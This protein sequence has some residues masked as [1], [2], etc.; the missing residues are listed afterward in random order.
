MP[1]VCGLSLTTQHLEDVRG[2]R[3]LAAVTTVG[4]HRNPDL[5]LCPAIP[6]DLTQERG[7]RTLVERGTRHGDTSATP[8]RLRCGLWGHLPPVGD[9][10]R[11]CG[12]MG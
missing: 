6:H 11:M 4:T 9:T 2:A 3:A 8:P 7:C 1:T 10:E 12:V 5:L